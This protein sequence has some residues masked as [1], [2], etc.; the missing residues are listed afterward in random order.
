MF[1]FWQSFHENK[2]KKF[3][4]PLKVPVISSRKANQN[5]C[6]CFIYSFSGEINRKI[7]FVLGVMQVLES[8]L[9][10]K[11]FFELSLMIANNANPPFKCSYT[12]LVTFNFFYALDNSNVWCRPHCQLQVQRRAVRYSYVIQRSSFKFKNSSSKTF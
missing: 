12:F 3:F 5:I 4:F 11:I 7:L 2:M 8:T 10:K 6:Y 1:L 9:K